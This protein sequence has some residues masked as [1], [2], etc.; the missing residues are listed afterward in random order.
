VQERLAP[1]PGTY[2]EF[3]ADVADAV[4]MGASGRLRE[5]PGVQWRTARFAEGV[6][7]VPFLAAQYDVSVWVQERAMFRRT[8]SRASRATARVRE[9]WVWQ[10]GKSAFRKL[11]ALL[12]DTLDSDGPEMRA[13]WQTIGDEIARLSQSLAERAGAQTFAASPQDTSSGRWPRRVPL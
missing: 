13:A 10:R 4:H 5:L 6:G 8:R 9:G 2:R 12:T 7:A 11:G 3:L 1:E